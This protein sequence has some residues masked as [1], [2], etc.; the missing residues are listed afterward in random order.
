MFRERR[1]WRKMTT[2][3][4]TDDDMEAAIAREY[5]SGAR[6]MCPNCGQ[7]VFN[8]HNGWKRHTEFCPIT[9]LHQAVIEASVTGSSQGVLSIGTRRKVDSAVGAIQ[10]QAR[11]EAVRL[12]L[13]EVRRAVDVAFDGSYL[14]AVGFREDLLE[15]IDALSKDPT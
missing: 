13:E 6:A 5:A 4:E 8:T 12:A 10:E 9:M 1:P 14:D 2:M 11:A 3:T 15:A 7:T